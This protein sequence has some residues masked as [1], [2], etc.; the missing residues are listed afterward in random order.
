LNSSTSER[1]G[2]DGGRSADDIAAQVFRLT[3][4]LS[5]ETLAEAAAAL[6]ALGLEPKAFFVLDGIEERPYPAA[7]ARHLSMPR[8]TISAYLAALEKQG[9]IGRAIDPADQR[10]HRLTLT[11][12]GEDALARARCDLFARYEARLAR[13]GPADQARF[14]ELLA[15]VIG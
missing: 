9:L 3:L 7:L 8:P 2:A 12:A 4:R 10:R 15:A 11:T 13:L 14:A 5:T 6:Q 1:L